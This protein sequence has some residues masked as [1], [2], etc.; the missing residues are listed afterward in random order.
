MLTYLK[1]ASNQ[2]SQCES[3]M[4]PRLQHITN[5]VQ[6]ILCWH[7]WLRWVQPIILWAKEGIRKWGLLCQC[8]NTCTSNF[9]N[10]STSSIGNKSVVRTYQQHK[11]NTPMLTHLE[12]KKEKQDFFVWNL[13]SKVEELKSA[14]PTPSVLKYPD[15]SPTPRATKPWPLPNSTRASKSKSASH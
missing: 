1:G 6:R 15:G 11:P 2:V 8:S 7:R 13:G 14:A 12:S 5:R 10:K 3:P 9:L 4:T